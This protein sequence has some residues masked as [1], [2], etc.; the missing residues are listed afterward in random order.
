MFKHNII[1]QITMIF[2]WAPSNCKSN[3]A[4]RFCILIY[5]ALQYI[6]HTCIPLSNKLDIAIKFHITY[7]LTSE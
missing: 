7:L 4:I 5:T 3:M 1:I 2:M 6:R